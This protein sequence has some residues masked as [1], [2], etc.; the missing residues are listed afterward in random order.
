MSV[1]PLRRKLVNRPKMPASVPPLDVLAALPIPVLVIDPSEQVAVANAAAEAFF[2]ASVS[3]LIE[4]GWA[5]GL[6][7]DNPLIALIREARGVDGGYAAYDTE[8]IFLGGRS[9]RAD[10]FVTPLGDAAGWTIL[11]FQTR[12]VATMVDRQMDHQGAA[13]SAIGVAAML[14][15]EIKNPLSGIRGAAQLLAETVDADGREL[16]DLI[17]DEV[18]RVRTLI[19]SREGFTDTRPLDIGSENIH[20]ILGHVRRIAEQGFAKGLVIKERYDPSLPEVAGN[21]DALVQV[22]LNLV[23]NA[24]E[25][26]GERGGEVM[27]TTGYRHGLRVAV[28]G[29]DR[30]ISLPLEI[31]IVDTGDGAPAAVA[32]HMFEPFVTSK[33]S[34]GGLGLALV[35]KIVGDHGGIIEYER[36]ADPARTV[37]R[38][39]LPTA[40]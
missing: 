2:N 31:C 11:S 34:G 6:H 37:F 4:R 1:F 8:I 26:I 10:V 29:S 35:A 14:A 28:Q 20:A 5:H 30:R 39:L 13:R 27:L 3:S 7:V 17:R 24:A 33:R 18:D 40:E 38:V 9:V 19:D 22:F 32:R 16:T 15:H 23:K 25:A 21:R 12:A 36:I